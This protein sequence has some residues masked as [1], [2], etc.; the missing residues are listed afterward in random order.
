VPP[1]EGILLG[2]GR[3]FD[4]IRKLVGPAGGS[5]PGVAVGPGDDCAVLEDGLVVSVDLSVEDVH[6]RR[7][8]ISLEEAGYRAAGAALSDLAAMAADPLG[9]LVSMALGP[10]EVEEA[11]RKLQ[12]GVEEAGRAV[13]VPVLGGDLSRSP[14]PVVLD[15]IVLGRVDQPLL[16]RGSRPGDEV[17]VTGWLGGSGAAVDAWRRGQLP[18]EPIRARFARPTPR[19]RE[20]RWLA[21]RAPLHAGIDLSDGLAGDAGHLAAASGMALII[22]AERLPYLS[23]L[24]AWLGDRGSCL[25]FAL[26]GGE[27]YEVCVTAPPGVLG[28]LAGPFQAEFGIPLTRVGRVEE[29]SGVRVE[30]FPT[31][32]ERLA[33]GF[34][35]FEN[36]EEG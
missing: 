2:P 11:A 1:S 35:H 34:S 3:E 16:R 13:G 21:A 12:A 29:G 28:P 27:D 18:P 31:E 25:H 36:V 19:I 20:A 4:L 30:G 33:G 6:F 17:W 15:V 23:E 7:S 32:R 26:S 10:E 8:W 9:L 5:A 22:D 24:E 14:G